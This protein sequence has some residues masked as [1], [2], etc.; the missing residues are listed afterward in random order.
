MMLNA[1]FRQRKRARQGVVKPRVSSGLVTV[2]K[3]QVDLK[4]SQVIARLVKI[5]KGIAPERKF[6]DTT[7][8]FINIADT[9]GAVA[10]LTAI[11]QD[12]TISGRTGNKIRVKHVHIQVRLSTQSIDS[13]VESF[14]R[15][16]LV[17][18]MQQVA[19]T[20][21]TVPNIVRSSADPRNSLI[22]ITTQ[23]R[24][25]VLYWF[26][27]MDATMI[28]SV[29]ATQSARQE[30]QKYFDIPVTFND[31]AG[32]DIQKNGLYLICWTSDTTDVGDADGIVRVTY[33]DD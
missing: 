15:F 16:A 33:I 3:K 1:G 17:Q 32:T 11:P 30:F 7:I 9:V 31:T 29:N 18:D 21:P 23:G 13:L 28:R 10:H 4:Q 20:P 24:F 14:Y 27:V 6:F 26:P 2:S 12:D 22:N 25:K 19:D 8:T 5:T